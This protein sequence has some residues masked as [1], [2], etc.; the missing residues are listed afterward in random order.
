MQNFATILYNILQVHLIIDYREEAT[1]RI[2]E[3]Y[4]KKAAEEDFRPLSETH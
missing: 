2:A 4:A 3:M 1:K